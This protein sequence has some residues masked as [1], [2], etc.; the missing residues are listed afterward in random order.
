MEKNTSTLKKEIYNLT[1]S[2]ALT[3]DFEGIKQLI[4]TN[5][6]LLLND[7][8]ELG[9][10]K[11]ILGAVLYKENKI[12]NVNER[13]IYCVMKLLNESLQISQCNI[14]A[15]YFSVEKNIISLDKLGWDIKTLDSELYNT[16]GYGFFF[17]HIPAMSIDGYNKLISLG[18]NDEDIET[19]N[20]QSVLFHVINAKRPTKLIRH[21]YEQTNNQSILN[22][23]F[24]PIKTNKYGNRLTHNL[25]K[26]GAIR[27]IS[28]LIDLGF[29]DKF[30]QP[31]LYGEYP[32]HRVVQEWIVNDIS[33]FGG[34]QQNIILTILLDSE[35]IDLNVKTAKGLTPIHIAQKKNKYNLIDLLLAHGADATIKRGIK[36]GGTSLTDKMMQQDNKS[37]KDYINVLGRAEQQELHKI[38]SNQELTQSK[39]RKK[40]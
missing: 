11:S 8:E 24:D 40:I 36:E 22:K 9:V 10:L 31:N 3:K 16:K 2:L 1:S 18:L 17:K 37:S 33:F 39:P 28:L 12:N 4:L 27:E 21:I 35:K 25:I 29:A 14:L 5:R 15:S 19:A 30:N 6:D 23:L 20:H 13:I 26:A 38:R 34:N 32:I 7:N